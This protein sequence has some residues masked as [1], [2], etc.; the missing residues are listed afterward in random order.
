MFFFSGWFNY[1]SWT[2]WYSLDK[3]T[4]I[5]S[6]VCPT[7][8]I[9]QF[10]VLNASCKPHNHIKVIFFTQKKKKKKRKHMKVTSRE[11]RNYRIVVYQHFVWLAS[12]HHMYGIE[13]EP[14]FRYTGNQHVLCLRHKYE[15]LTEWEEVFNPSDYE[16]RLGRS[17]WYIS[18]VFKLVISRAIQNLRIIVMYAHF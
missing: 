5:A 11:S 12:F 10:T 1:I 4:F 14:C 7:S 16:W 9:H 13:D 3:I 18:G 8:N 2:S 6:R 17:P 15:N